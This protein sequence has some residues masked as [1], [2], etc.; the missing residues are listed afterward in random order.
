M[1]SQRSNSGFTLVELISAMAASMILVFGFSSVIVFARSELT[2]TN[3]RVGLSYDQV[4]INRYVRT[5]L[6]STISDSMQIFT[7]ASA[8]AAAT[9]STT[10]PILRAV[11]ADSTV[12]HLDI[13][14]NTLQWMVD[15]TTHTPADCNIANLVFTEQTGNHGKILNIDMDLCSVTDT[16]ACQ[17]S[18]TL[19]N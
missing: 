18:I 8:E 3:T 17:W 5:K 13:T 12:Y 1:I 7:D 10:G 15:S 14:S 9:T 4:L 19:R 16:L 2:K 11:A 6:T